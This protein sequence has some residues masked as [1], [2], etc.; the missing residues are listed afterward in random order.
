MSS[1]RFLIHPGET[2]SDLMK[3]QGITQEEL[4]QRAGV[5]EAFLGE[6]IRGEKDVTEELATGLHHAHF[7][8]KSFWL[9]LQANYDAER[10]SRPYV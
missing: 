2:I 1:F 8:P 9:K 3:A 10:T 6:V 5:P 4:A 7:A